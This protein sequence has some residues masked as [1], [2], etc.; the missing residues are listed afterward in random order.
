MLDMANMLILL[1]TSPQIQ[2][3]IAHRVASI[4]PRAC[5]VNLHMLMLVKW[6]QD[7]TASMRDDEDAKP[8]VLS[9]ASILFD[10]VTHEYTPGTPVLRDVTFTVQGG[11]T[12]ALVCCTLCPLLLSN[13]QLHKLVPFA[14]SCLAAW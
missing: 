3:S 11:S 2:A 1:A 10:H 7:C 4:A 8:L 14:H 13:I 6:G 5:H 12:T 9:S